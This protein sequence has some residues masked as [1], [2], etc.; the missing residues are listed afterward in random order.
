[1]H[2]TY[3]VG[4]HEA[5]KAAQTHPRRTTETIRRTT[6][7]EESHAR[8]ADLDAPGGS[9]GWSQTARGGQEVR[10]VALL[11][12]DDDTVLIPAPCGAVRGESR[13]DTIR[14]GMGTTYI[15]S[16]M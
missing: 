1:M 7:G 10:G 4:E 13:G 12:P 8:P 11:G 3:A 15:E 6:E 16:T 9:S 14:A 5:M 2:D